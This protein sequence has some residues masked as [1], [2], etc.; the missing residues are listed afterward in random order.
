MTLQLGNLRESAVMLLQVRLG[1]VSDGIAGPNTQAALGS[2]YCSP[3]R[4]RAVT[5]ARLAPEGHPDL[6][7]PA[8][9]AWGARGV[10]GTF[11]PVGVMLHHTAG[12]MR[13]E[14]PAERMI[15]GREGLSGPLA[16]FGVSRNGTIDCYT[17]GRTHSA[18]SGD[19]RVLS[20]LIADEPP[21]APRDDNTSGN[22]WFYAIEVDHTG[23][24]EDDRARWLRAAHVAV[25]LCRAWGWPA[26]RVIGHSEWTSRKVDPCVDMDVFRGAVGLRLAHRLHAAR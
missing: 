14:I 15:D 24:H 23:A 22:T 5:G 7:G 4:F 9:R 18:G 13:D 8:D 2:D 6:T 12:P 26:S 19:E 11:E 3:A 21:P 20:A 17:V 25:T 1:L 16:N 10:S